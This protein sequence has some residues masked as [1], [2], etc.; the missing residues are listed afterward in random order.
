M[1]ININMKGTFTAAKQAVNNAKQAAGKAKKRAGDIFDELRSRTSKGSQ[2][3]KRMS[4]PE[5]QLPRPER[6]QQRAYSDPGRYPFPQ[7]KQFTSETYPPKN[8]RDTPPSPQGFPGGAYPPDGYE[9]TQPHPQS[10]PPGEHP[11]RTPRAGRA[12]R[13]RPSGPGE[14]PADDLATVR[15]QARET[16]GLDNEKSTRAFE[17]ETLEDA[18]AMKDHLE[19]FS[20]EI[21]TKSRELQQRI[22]NGNSLQKDKELKSLSEATRTLKL[23]MLDAFRHLD[24]LLQKQSRDALKIPEDKLRPQDTEHNSGTPGDPDAMEKALAMRTALEAFRLEV[25]EKFRGLELKDDREIDNARYARSEL[26]K[27]VRRSLDRVQEKIDKLENQGTADSTGRP[28][29][30]A[31]SS[32]GR[33]RRTATQEAGRSEQSKPKVESTADEQRAQAQKRAQADRRALGEKRAQAR[34]TLGLDE[35]KLSAAYVLSTTKTLEDAVPMKKQLQ[36][37]GR[38]VWRNFDQRVKELVQENGDPMAAGETLRTLQDAKS[39][40]EAEMK[41]GI[42]F[43]DGLMQA[44]SRKRLGFASDRLNSSTLI[45]G[46]TTKKDAAALKKDLETFSNEV[47][48]EFKALSRRVHP[49]RNRN[50]PDATEKFQKILK[51]KEV[52]IEELKSA[53]TYVDY[54]LRQ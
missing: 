16:L 42:A 38:A 35:T 36:I 18:V 51:A 32:G 11:R 14:F 27:E 34:K 48:K 9:S 41:G 23:E 40:L 30:P 37:F 20:K 12:G 25:K 49:D 6:E 52:L 3:R 26:L 15:A 29:R 22:E 24:D 31:P 21:S 19:K 28:E 13:P 50:D 5:P 43:L 33:N 39:T 44:E 53:T 10:P 2:P 1:S 8:Y 7:A 54:V 17:C 46:T 47:T 45:S 4:M